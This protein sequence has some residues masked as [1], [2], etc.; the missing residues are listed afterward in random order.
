M[1]KSRVRVLA[2]LAVL[3]ISLL[4]KPIAAL[5]DCFCNG[6]EPYDVIVKNWQTF[7]PKVTAMHS[8]NAYLAT[9]MG[10]QVF[11]VPKLEDLPEIR[12]KMYKCVDYAGNEKKFAAIYDG[13]FN[14]ECYEALV[15]KNDGTYTSIPD[16]IK[17]KGASCQ[18]ELTTLGY[19]FLLMRESVTDIRTYD[20]NISATYVADEL[21][22]NGTGVDL[23]TAIMDIYKAIGQ[24]EYDIKFAFT[25]D[26]SLTVENSPI[27][28]EI[29]LQLSQGNPIDTSDG[30][31]WVF[32]TRSNPELYWVKASKDGVIYDSD[33]RQ[34][35]GSSFSTASK[36]SVITLADFCKY[37]YGIMDIYGEPVMSSSERSILL[38][39][40]GT[41][42]P[43]QSVTSECVEAIENFIAKGI[44]SPD[45]DRTYLN[46]N[47]PIDARYFLTLLMRISDRDSRM[48]YKD[49]QITLDASLLNRGYYAT[50]VS[51]E[52]S[53]ILDVKIDE[54]AAYAST[55]IPYNIPESEVR[56][57]FGD[58]F[59]ENKKFTSNHVV[60]KDSSGNIYPLSTLVTTNASSGVCHLAESVDL[61][62]TPSPT[63]PFGECVGWSNGSLQISLFSQP[64]LELLTNGSYQICAINS[65]GQIVGKPYLV[66]P[67]RSSTVDVPETEEFD[68]DAEELDMA[69]TTSKVIVFDIV[70]GSENSIKFKPTGSSAEVTLAEVMLHQQVEGNPGL[71][72]INENDPT[73]MCIRK[74]SDTQ[75]QAIN[76]QSTQAFSSLVTSS[77]NIGQTYEG[78]CYRD[79]QLMVKTDWLKQA[80]LINSDIVRNGEILML[81]TDFTDVYLDRENKI[82]VAGNTIY[83]LQ[84]VSANEVWYEDK[85]DYVV[86]FRAVFGWTGDFLLFKDAGNGIITVSIKKDSS[87]G[88]AKSNYGTTNVTLRE[89][90]TG[91]KNIGN[92]AGKYGSNKMSTVIQTVKSTRSGGKILMA[93]SYPYANW[94]VIANVRLFDTSADASDWLFVFKPKN[95]SVNGNMITHDDTDAKARLK[96]VFGEMSFSDD[97]I[98]VWSYRLDRSNNPQ[99]LPDGFEWTEEYGWTYTPPTIVNIDNFLVNYF[100]DTQ[101]APKNVLPIFYESGGK[102]RC[103]NYNSYSYNDNGTTKFLDYGMIPATDMVQLN[104]NLPSSF[105]AS[106]FNSAAAGVMSAMNWV[107]NKGSGNLKQTQTRIPLCKLNSSGQL[108]ET[109]LYIEDCT[110]YPTMTS[111]A[112]WC[113]GLN[114]VSYEDIMNN[115]TVDNTLI[116]RGTS[117]LTVSYDSTGTMHLY[118][119]ASEISKDSYDDMKFLLLRAKN[120]NGS[121]EYI[122][123]ESQL[124]TFT[125]STSGAS[126]DGAQR[127]M[128]VLGTG[129]A[130]KHIDVIDWDEFTLRRIL[131]D[132]EFTIAILMVIALFIIPRVCLFVFLML[133]GLAVIQNVKIV[134][135]FCDRVFDVYKFLTFKRRDVHTFKPGV[136]FRNSL[137][138]MALFALF[139]DGTIIHVYEWIVQFM[140]Y[141]IIGWK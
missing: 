18:R 6:S 134:Q 115:G 12:K 19:D 111:P 31:G 83:R 102:L 133:L 46:W 13:Y 121:M 27:Q 119:G 53:N 52:T 25:K 63:T 122:Y 35:S 109:T 48:T 98:A 64:V 132:F 110:T 30:A 70:A 37:A 69:S 39:L 16:I 91:G 86:N 113:L 128:Q 43:Y 78:F 5:A 130:S 60:V 65:E 4:S 101:D 81:G 59:L 47:A 94:F 38:Q 55:Y 96:A 24:S 67:S 3:S 62:Q 118:Q 99:Y 21:H 117:E 77:S 123:S 95:V 8:L 22:L 84:D 141:F 105:V 97:S 73:D 11:Y 68:E 114:T 34:N 131:E 10:Q 15:R 90:V 29:H 61:T 57:V 126:S 20:S 108:E 72:P 26:D 17:D 124:N 56:A 139:M 136:A 23:S 127:V 58:D 9:D 129:V 40:Y 36:S 106:G 104:K 87:N 74:I 7:R 32:V 44:I 66:T 49:V 42:I 1:N 137:I 107:T 88:T 89:T 51:V 50:Q 45:D 76:V 75:Y 80:K 140:Y 41:D 54:L 92:G 103:V 93:S 28:S 71:Y 14:S 2:G 85:G 33:A 138:A 100:T 112:L 82:V 116:L 79:E 120:I 125:L 135:I